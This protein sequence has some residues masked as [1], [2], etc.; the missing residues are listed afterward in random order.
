MAKVGT[1]RIYH[2]GSGKEIYC[3]VNFYSKSKLFKIIDF[4]EDIEKWYGSKETR[5]N[6]YGTKLYSGEICAKS[7]DEC[8][9]LGK[10]VYSEYY[11]QNIKEDKII[12]YQLKT[13]HPRPEFHG[14]NDK[15]DLYHA[16]S[17]AIGLQYKV[18]Y[19]ITI[20]EEC[21]ISN[22]NYEDS[23]TPDEGTRLG[24]ERLNREDGHLGLYDWHKISYTGEAHLFF[25]NVEKGLLDMI[26]NVNAFFGES[27][28][29]LLE[30]IE[31]GKFL[32]Q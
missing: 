5:E 32:M 17:L 13:N 10:K 27:P 31:S 1:E 28:T 11:D 22:W 14:H 29:V 9:D 2:K 26:T 8:I 16:P 25:K 24:G 20:G 15:R 18:M 3:Q 7:Y 12:C 30:K 19:R 23:K 4:P 21:F 6:K